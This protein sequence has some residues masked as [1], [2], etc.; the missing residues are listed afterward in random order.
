MKHK[1]KYIKE[2]NWCDDDMLNFVAVSIND[3]RYKNI[4]WKFHKQY[5]KDLYL[6]DIWYIYWKDYKNV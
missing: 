3:K 6:K 5:K 1:A 2:N 4:G